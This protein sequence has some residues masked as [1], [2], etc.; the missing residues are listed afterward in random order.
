VL[1]LMRKPR[2]FVSDTT[3]DYLP[4]FDRTIEPSRFEFI[5]PPASADDAVPR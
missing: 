4:S 2:P 1:A 3:I 5:P